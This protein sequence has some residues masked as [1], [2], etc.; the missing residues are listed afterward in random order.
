MSA[1]EKKIL[2]VSG[3]C[4]LFL[5]ALLDLPFSSPNIWKYSSKAWEGPVCQGQAGERGLRL[6]VCHPCPAFPSELGEG[7]RGTVDRR[8]PGPSSPPH[9]CPFSFWNFLHAPVSKSAFQ[10]SGWNS[11]ASARQLMPDDL[12]KTWRKEPELPIWPNTPA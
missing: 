10:H 4:H 12:R 7:E 11:S 5:S 2:F 9:S 3:S 8:P 6:A 1:Q